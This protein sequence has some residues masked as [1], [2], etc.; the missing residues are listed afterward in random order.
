MALLFVPATAPS[1]AQES[2]TF[3]L[4]LVTK[5]YYDTT[6]KHNIP[7]LQVTRNGVSHSINF[8]D[9]YNATG[10][11]TRWGYPT[12]EV[13]EEEVGNLA[14]YYQRG[15]VDWHWRADLGRYVMERRLAW[16]YF[17]G[18]LGGSVD[19][20]VEPGILNPHPGDLVGPWGH[21]VSDFSIDGRYTGFKSFYE[22]L[23][24]VDAFGYPKTDAR[25]DLRAAGT[26][27]IGTPGFI[28]Q[29]FQA[30][31]FE[32]HLGDPEPVK[33][34]LLG[35]DLRN[36]NYPNSSWRTYAA[37]RAAAALTPGQRYTIPR[38]TRGHTARGQPVAAAPTATPRPRTPVVPTATPRPVATATPTPTATPVA[39]A[40]PLPKGTSVWFGTSNRG[41]VHYDG[42]NWRTYRSLGG[43]IPHDTINDIF[44]AADGTKWFA[45]QN[46]LAALRGAAWPLYN[47]RNQGFAGNKVTAV[48]ADGNLVWIG[49]DGG[50]A[51]FGR[52]DG[53]GDIDWSHLD[54]SNSE[55]PS[56]VVRDVLVVN[57]Q[58]NRVWLATDNGVAYYNN[59]N[60]R[61]FRSELPIV[62]TLSLAEDASG[63]IWVGTNG[64]G[65]SVYNS[66]T[67][68]PHNT[69]NSALI[70]DTVRNI[71]VGPD[72]RVWLA[73]PGGVNV[74]DG[75]NWTRHTIFNTGI[76]SNDVY[77]IAID[78][79]GRV[80]VATNG[81]AS[82]LESG[83]WK[84][85]AVT[86][87]TLRAVAVE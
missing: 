49:T 21:K 28:R 63:N 74:Y 20:G 76:A 6:L 29:Y 48:H 68:L 7:N 50:G 55:L 40:T 32:H 23:G 65:V 18:G 37:F 24:G 86:Y 67:W 33:L 35:D 82:L 15:V 43:P 19:Q 44:I 58:P 30:A 47:T 31:V 38:V 84:P 80:W 41:V 85:L 56:N 22:S 10:G 53:S 17:G 73:T 64:G 45:T 87:Q 9:H 4:A 12:S 52:I 5:N 72:G 75:T 62:D 77:D 83:D 27:R 51:S 36:L 34:R 81:G 25:A 70:H 59:G 2:T 26:L 57:E 54:A 60:W 78:K 16:D 3:S 42:A 46:G 39:A 69:N 71:T 1:H 11:L 79:A 61:V 66:V 13:I 8:L 14:Q